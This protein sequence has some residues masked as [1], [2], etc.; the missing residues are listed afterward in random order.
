VEFRKVRFA[1]PILHI[2]RRLAWNRFASHAG[3]SWR[4]TA[5]ACELDAVEEPSCHYNDNFRISGGIRT[6]S[7]SRPVDAHRGSLGCVARN[8][9]DHDDSWRPMGHGFA[10]NHWVRSRHVGTGCVVSRC[11]PVWVEARGTFTAQNQL[12]LLKDSFINH[13][14]FW[15]KGGYYFPS[16]E[17]A[18]CPVVGL[19]ANGTRYTIRSSGNWA[20]NSS[21][22][23]RPSECW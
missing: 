1:A 15:L 20:L 3:R 17:F 4:F 5:S 12:Q 10:R 22:N 18:I 7:H 11:S 9:A 14:N 21:L 13:R 23:R 8:R 6:P 16:L 19:F 2:R